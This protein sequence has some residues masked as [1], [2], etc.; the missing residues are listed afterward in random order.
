MRG[1]TALVLFTFAVLAPLA[2]VREA[3]AVDVDRTV[4]AL[5]ALRD[6]WARDPSA[7]PV[8]FETR[9]T[10]WQT[11]PRWLVLAGERTP[12]EEDP[13]VMTHPLFLLRWA[14]GSLAVVDA[15]LSPDGARRFGRP[16]ELLGAE[17]TVCGEAP[18]AGIDPAKVRAVVFSHL[19]VDH[20]QG[21]GALCGDGAPLPVRVSPEQESSDERFEAA[22]REELMALVR[23]GCARREP[24]ALVDEG[25]PAPGLAG[26]PGL[27]RVPV[28]GHTPGSQLVVVFVH[29]GDG[30]PRGVIVSGDVV[31]HRAGIRHDR[32]KPWWYRKLLVRE[33]DDLQEQ[34]RRLLARLDAA[35]FEILVDHHLPVPE[36]STRVPCP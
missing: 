2:A 3:S 15:G 6:R 17:A 29:D 16:A 10:A 36:G 8:S 5:E 19:H 35:G 27:H 13:Y 23:S 21:L 24:F 1:G 18:F 4:A 30:P 31:N 7:L 9:L 26:L 28:P 14:D 33:V 34:N 22:G 11:A 20:L 12:D 32:P 25:G